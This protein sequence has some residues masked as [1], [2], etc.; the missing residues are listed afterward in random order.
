MGVATLNTVA[1]VEGVGCGD[2]SDGIPISVSVEI[3]SGKS[4]TGLTVGIGT[5]GIDLTEGAYLTS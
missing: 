2:I 5:V 1:V 4:V 3:I